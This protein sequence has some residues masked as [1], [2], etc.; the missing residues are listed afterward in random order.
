MVALK[1]SIPWNKGMKGV[2][3]AWNKGKH[4]LSDEAK[5]RIGDANRGRLVSLETRKKMS[6]AGKGRP[7]TEE[8]KRRMSEGKKGVKAYNWK[9]DKAGYK[10]IHQWI[11]RCL[12]KANK[13][14]GHLFGIKCRGLEKRFE[15]A[16]ISGEYKRDLK[17]YIQLGHSCHIKYDGISKKVWETRIMRYGKT[18]HKKSANWKGWKHSVESKEEM[19]K[20][21]KGK[22]FS[23]EHKR[24]LGESMKKMWEKRKLLVGTPKI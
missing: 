19:S 23:E 11:T 14:E 24:N 17:D 18:G 20:Q 4:H 15:W 2:Q 6:I 16:N 1:G 9:G 12:G 3:V 5:K 7:K 13:C 8:T 10:A 21:R 22:K